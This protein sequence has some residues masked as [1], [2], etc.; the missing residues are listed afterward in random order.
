MKAG[1]AWTYN[2]PAEH[3]VAWIAVYDGSVTTSDG[4]VTNGE[5]AVFDDDAEV[6][7]SI[8]T[9]GASSD[10]AKFMLGM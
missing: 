7:R 5:L 3:D 10:G 8:L 6:D 1:E 4:M 9:F 2:V